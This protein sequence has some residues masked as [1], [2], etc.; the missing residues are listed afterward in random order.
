MFPLLL[1]LFSQS[2]TSLIGIQVLQSHAS[3]VS[4]SHLS[5]EIEKL[6]V[7]HMRANSRMKIGGG[8]DSTADSYAEDVE[9]EANLYFHQMFSGELSIDATIQMLTRSK[10]ST[11]KRYVSSSVKYISLCKLL[12]FVLLHKTSHSDSIF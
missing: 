2:I 11:E 7:T 1:A 9:T 4:S 6:D 8:S 10:E 3:V 12:Y 5:E